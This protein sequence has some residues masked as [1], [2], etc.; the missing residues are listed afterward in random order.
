MGV[1]LA[2]GGCGGVCAQA[3]STAFLAGGWGW[4]TTPTPHRPPP[5]QSCGCACTNGLGS[6]PNPL[7]HVHPPIHMGSTVARLLGAIA[8]NL[9]LC[10]SAIPTHGESVHQTDHRKSMAV[11]QIILKGAKQEIRGEPSVEKHIIEQRTDNDRP[12]V[13]LHVH[14]PRG[15]GVPAWQEKQ[16]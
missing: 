1:A 4:A 9:P 11:G 15:G 6:K 12:R 13:D 10:P 8:T 16:P 7:R 3:R 5:T 2:W 14:G